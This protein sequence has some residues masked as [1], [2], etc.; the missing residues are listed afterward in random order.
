MLA[1]RAGVGARSSRWF[2]G[3]VL[4]W[5][6]LC[7]KPRPGVYKTHLGVYS[8]CLGVSNTC[9]VVSSGRRGSLAPHADSRKLRYLWGRCAANRTRFAIRGLCLSLP[10]DYSLS[11]SCSLSF[12]L[13]LS[14]SLYVT[15][16]LSLRLSLCPSDPLPPPPLPFSWGLPSPRE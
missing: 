5:G 13:S 2:A 12:S 10:L 1:D 15:L 6:T 8:T 9:P 7:L 4:F 14:L 16:S 11:H 3:A